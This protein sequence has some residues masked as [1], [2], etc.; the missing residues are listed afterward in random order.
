MSAA[1][2]PYAALR[3]RDYRLFLSA[4]VV[5]SIGGEV[6]ATAVGWELYQR[7]NSYDALGY[8]G[9]AQFLPVL[10]LAL[11]AGHAADHFS[12]RLIFQA[13]QLLSILASVI[14]AA[15]SHWH[16]PIELIYGCL[17]LSGVARAFTAPARSAMLPQV[18]PLNTLGNAVTWNS[19]GWQIA[20]VG[21]PAVGGLLLWAARGQAAPAYMFAS[22]TSLA[23]I[24]L[25]FLM[26]LQ[27]SVARPR[28]G[29][30]LASLLAGAKFVW[31]TEMLL[32]AITL[33]LFAVLFGGATALL[34]AYATDILHIDEVGFG[35]LRAAPAAGALV[36]AFVIAHRP[37]LRRPGQGVLLL[38]VAGFGIAILIVFV[39][40]S[41]DFWLSFT[42]LAL[43]GALDN[44]SVV[45][46]GTA[47]CKSS[48]LMK[49]AAGS[50]SAVNSVFISSSNELGSFESGKTA[51]WF[52]PVTSVVSGGAVTILVVLLAAWRWPR[53]VALGPLHEL[54]PANVEDAEARIAIQEEKREA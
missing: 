41:E 4:G 39:K 45:E 42:M 20:N 47:R 37:P 27:T 34:P 52:G 36:M 49:C 23:C 35:W 3:H 16:G 21:G 2:D 32:A 7:T 33:D 26:R 31:R 53:L 24:L 51:A 5:A 15:L 30:S 22:G 14:L 29:R 6:Q 25:L 43:A 18:V 28:P 44:I 12:R 1:H 50:G 19:S 48:R 8:V 54:P 17:V 40:P 13:S 46:S 9:L 11:P 10:F 38:A